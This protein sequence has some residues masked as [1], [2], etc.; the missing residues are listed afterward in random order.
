MNVALTFSASQPDGLL[1]AFRKAIDDKNIKT[2]LYND[3]GDFYHTDHQTQN[4]AWF[5][6]RLTSGQLIFNA[7]CPKGGM[8]P[9]FV[10]AYYHGHLTETFIFHFHD[11]FTVATSSAYAGNG[12][13]VDDTKQ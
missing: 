5:R 12:D 9:Y 7:I 3:S 8:L 10:Y 11:N 2:W 13:I 4:R 1:K 6:P